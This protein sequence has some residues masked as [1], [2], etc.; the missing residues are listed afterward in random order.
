MENIINFDVSFLPSTIKPGDT[1]G[2][3]LYED[4]TGISEWYDVVYIGDGKAV[5]KQKG[6]D[7]REK[8]I[9]H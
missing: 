3:I 1:V 4:H 8:E 2:S 7:G 5:A 9:P 6:K